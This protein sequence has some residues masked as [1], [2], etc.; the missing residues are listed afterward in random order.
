MKWVSLLLIWL[1]FIIC[2]N[3]SICKLQNI[4][5]KEMTSSEDTTCDSYSDLQIC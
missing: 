4:Q 5:K 1:Y 3:G 2:M